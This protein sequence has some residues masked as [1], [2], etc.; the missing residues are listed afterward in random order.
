MLFKESAFT[1]HEFTVSDVLGVLLNSFPLVAA[2]EGGQ[3]DVEP[4]SNV[5]TRAPQ[6]PG[7]VP[8]STGNTS[9]I[10]P[11]ASKMCVCSVCVVSQGGMFT[12]A[13]VCTH[14][15][16][17][18]YVSVH[19]YACVCMCVCTYVCILVIRVM[20]PIVCNLFLRRLDLPQTFTN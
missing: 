3:L 17:C 4:Q 13:F 5:P 15:Y 6:T 12:Y 16:L 8:L 2:M 18:A 20:F 9:V 19:V 7:Q 10:K 1:V 11:G 14:P